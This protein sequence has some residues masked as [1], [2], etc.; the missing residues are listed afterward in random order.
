MLKIATLIMLGSLAAASQVVYGVFRQ[1]CF[2]SFTKGDFGDTECVK[3]TF[4]KAI[5]FAIITGA[6]ILKVPQIMKILS[7][8]SV[9]GISPFSYYTETL[10]YVNTAALSMH[11]G[12]AFSVYGETLII[13]AQNAIIILLLWSYQKKV[14]FLEK[15]T[16]LAI[17]S[18][19]SYVLFTGDLITEDMWA[20]VSSSSIGLNIVSRVP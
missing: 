1:D 20:M 10:N 2:E 4:S 8:G 7:S 14:S 3:F 12:L 5:G 17:V 13:L 18:G 15:I 11:L 9:E 6:F 19:Y 16:F